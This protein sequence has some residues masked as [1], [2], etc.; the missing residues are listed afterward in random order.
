MGWVKDDID[1]DTVCYEVK[2]TIVRK[3]R[4]ITLSNYFQ[5][6]RPEGKMLN[7]IFVSLN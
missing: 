4:Q 6:E 3:K 5:L 2:A 7:L 1:C